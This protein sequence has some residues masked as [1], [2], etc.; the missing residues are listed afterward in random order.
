MKVI[1]VKDVA[2]LGAIGDEVQVKDGYAKNF[3]FPRK[4]AIEASKGALK[5]IEQKKLQKE[6][7]E[8]NLKNEAETLAEKIKGVSVTISMEAGEEDKLFGSVTGEMISDAL[9][10]EGVE[11]DKKKIHLEEP[12]KSLGVYS[13]EIKLHP[14]VKAQARIWVVKK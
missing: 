14:E 11:I 9:K 2:D 4:L 10:A 6:R 3:L 7:L 12:L 8:K 13:V 1:L 5:V